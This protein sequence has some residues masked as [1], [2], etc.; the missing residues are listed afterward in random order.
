M[1]HSQNSSQ[2]TLN[3]PCVAWQPQAAAPQNTASQVPQSYYKV[4]SCFLGGMAVPYRNLTAAGCHLCT[5]RAKAG[6]IMSLPRCKAAFA[7]GMHRRHIQSSIVRNECFPVLSSD[8]GST[9]PV[10]LLCIIGI[11]IDCTAVQQVHTPVANPGK[12]GADKLEVHGPASALEAAAQDQWQKQLLRI[13]P[14]YNHLS[15]W[16]KCIKACWKMHQGVLL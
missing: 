10:H 12:P 3:M 16:G 14:S 13:M 8:T 4:R 6:N 9:W 2:S 5:V 1:L 15:A 7:T 11:N